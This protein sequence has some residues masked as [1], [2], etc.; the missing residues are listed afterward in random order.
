[1]GEEEDDFDTDPSLWLDRIQDDEETPSPLIDDSEDVEEEDFSIEKE[2]DWLQRVRGH[3]D[4]D[5]VE[6]E[7]PVEEIE[8]VGEPEEQEPDSLQLEEETDLPTDARE[9]EPFE[10][11]PEV[12]SDW[13]TE[14]ALEGE[15]PDWLAALEGEGDRTPKEEEPLEEEQ[16]DWLTQESEAEDLPEWLA[17]FEG[18]E[19]QTPEEQEPLDEQQPEW[20]SQF[21]S[22]SDEPVPSEA[23]TP[24]DQE[25]DS[26]RL[27]EFDEAGEDVLKEEEALEQQQPEWLSEFDTPGDEP[28]PSPPE[29]GAETPSEREEDSEWLVE[30]DEAMEDIPGDEELPEELQPDWL[31]EFAEQEVE[32]P[33]PEPKETEAEQPSEAERA[34][35]VPDWLFE[36]EDS[37]PEIL[38][39]EVQAEGLEQQP[40]QEEGLPDWILGVPEEE[41]EEQVSEIEPEEAKIAPGDLPT[42]LAT[43]RPAERTEDE[44][45]DEGKV[46]TA[47]PLVGLSETL[48]AEPEIARLKRPPAYSVKLQVT[49]NQQ[50]H[51]KLW[52]QM[53]AGE[54]EPRE[55]PKP[56]ILTTQSLLRWLIALSLLIVIAGVVVFDSRLVPYPDPAL[57]PTEIL[58]TSRLITALPAEAPVMI[59]FNYEP[60]LSGEMDA[61]AAAVID[62]LMLKG[63]RL[64]LISTSPI[65]PVLAERFINRIQ[66]KHDYSSDQQ[67][68]NLGYVPGGISGLLGFAQIPQRVTPLSFG[69]LDAWET[70]P[71][72]GVMRLADFAM[73]VV[74]TDNPDTARA[75]VEQVQ[76][77]FGDTP[78]VMVVS[79]QAE[80]L[81]RPYHDNS[82]RQV[83]GLISSL[84][85]GAAYEALINRSS[86]VR[87]YW[88]AF[89]AGLFI[90]IGSILV[91]GAYNLI[92]VLLSRFREE[93]EINRETT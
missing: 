14:P 84:T 78:L 68:T 38:A 92:S 7:P 30:F 29:P 72:Q 24:S 21:D 81:V 28:V 56:P 35:D 8:P 85:G 67:Y 90:A 36:L 26:E 3:Q 31:S 70:Q 18:I 50:K 74:I 42:W 43:M 17:E 88:D 63:A 23:E 33:P 5:R 20:L 46:E 19:D 32:I 27:V 75:W 71:L 37:A 51:A 54:G 58:D 66:A 60:G 73:T 64:T 9:Q 49:E 57:I 41:A 16:P 62:H 61:S 1:E 65:G 89:S 10:D 4:S 77:M 59:A 22:A 6:Q 12:S 69:G 45:K 11:E 55:I 40:S 80:P 52:E 15:V 79:A 25:E 34:Q 48:A 39:E 76:P 44:R 93:R 87:S 53:L 86:L 47:G 91:G 2:P 82:T 13:D 83:D